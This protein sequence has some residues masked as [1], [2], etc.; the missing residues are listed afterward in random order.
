MVRGVFQSARPLGL[1]VTS[2]FFFSFFNPSQ[3]GAPPRFGI[4]LSIAQSSSFFSREGGMT[5]RGP[6][7][8]RLHNAAS[9]VLYLLPPHC[10][11]LPLFVDSLFFS[12]RFEDIEMVSQIL[13]ASAV[14]ASPPFPPTPCYAV[15]FHIRSPFFPTLTH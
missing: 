10:L 9:P 2:R 11:L 13:T 8:P 7:P 14:W 12:E 1:P 3:S 4:S 5:R 6:F 15:E